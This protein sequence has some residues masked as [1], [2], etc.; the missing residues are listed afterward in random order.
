MAGMHGLRQFLNH[1]SIVGNDGKVWV[2][3]T[4]KTPGYWTAL[5][6]YCLS[7]QIN[8]DKLI[9]VEKRQ[10]YVQTMALERAIT[11]KDGCLY[12][13]K[14]SGRKYSE[15]VVLNNPDNTNK[16]ASVINSCIREIFPADELKSF[17]IDLC[18]VVGELHDNVWSHGESTGLSMAQTWNEY[19]TN[20][21]VIEFALADC[22]LGFLREL[23]RV[24][25][26]VKN[27]I[28]AIQWCIV[29]GNTSKKRK[30]DDWG[31]SL[32]KDM[33]N[34]PIP[35][36]AKPKMSENNHMG[37]GLA[38]LLNLVNNYKGELW[39]ASGD[40]ILSIAQNGSRTFSFPPQNW[41]GVA[42]ACRFNTKNV[43]S[44]KNNNDDD[45]MAL[46]NLLE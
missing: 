10:G 3:G 33:M 28:E 35:D 45:I 39:L 31:Q 23:Q 42:I 30:N 26:Q 8:Y 2:D 37:M 25:I 20:Y 4:F 40:A 12:E 32:P 14:N 24:G 18:D 46:I 6:A 41:K 16:A 44:Y 15:L 7:N 13:R 9:I 43:K 29:E 22:G 11:G 38:K 1:G 27:D 17:V 34:N 19:G 5:A 36:I 21:P